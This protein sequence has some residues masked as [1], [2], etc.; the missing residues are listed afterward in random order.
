MG[1]DSNLLIQSVHRGNQTH[2]RFVNIKNNQIKWSEAGDWAA[3]TV[4]AANPSY[5]WG[6][7]PGSGDIQAQAEVR[8]GDQYLVSFWRGNEEHRQFI[9]IQ[10]NVLQWDQSSWSGAISIDSLDIGAGDM[11]AYG[12]W[13]F[14]NKL[15]QD[16]WRDNVGYSRSFSID[17]NDVVDWLKPGNWSEP[18]D[19]SALPGSGDMQS[20][21]NYII[22]DS[23][24]QD[25]WR[26]GE[27]RS[28]TVPIIGGEV[29]WTPEPEWSDP[30]QVSAL[31]GTG[32]FHASST[33]ACFI[34]GSIV[35]VPESYGFTRDCLGDIADIHILDTTPTGTFHTLVRQA[36]GNS[37]VDTQVQYQ[38][39]NGRVWLPETAGNHEREVLVYAGKWEKSNFFEHLRPV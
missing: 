27:G 18:I 35:I 33:S 4:T 32:D 17:N 9:P 36:G 15:M 22:G 37:V 6:A 10:G 14:G 21:N 19:I 34:E 12:L 25:Y 3:F 16:V 5:W 24:Y 23:L 20:M 13:R 39:G 28:R 31:P 38:N 1:N 8:I 7:L 11:Q 29:Q 26:G 2:Y 30:V